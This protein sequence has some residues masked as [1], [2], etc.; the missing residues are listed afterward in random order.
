MGQHYIYVN[1]TLPVLYF[2]SQPPF[3]VEEFLIK[4]ESLLTKED[5]ALL[6]KIINDDREVDTSNEVVK[7]I[8]LFSRGFQNDLTYFRA[9]RAK[10]DPADFLRGGRT[11]NQRYQEV[12]VQAAKNA[13]LLEAEKMIDQF[14]WEVWDNLVANSFFEIENI[15]IYALKLAVLDKYRDIRSTK[16]NEIFN[17]VND[18]E[19]L[20][21]SLYQVG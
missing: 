19:F 15:V 17:E 12:I 13:N 14:K 18:P 4:I 5:Y 8:I 1:A 6:M 20:E 7:N 16:G 11:G 21:E 10:K 3:T 9:E 2:E